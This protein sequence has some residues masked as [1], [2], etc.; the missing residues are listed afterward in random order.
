MN[1]K[2]IKTNKLL[3]LNKVERSILFIRGERVMI[4]ADLAELYGVTTK[5]L[6]EQVKRNIKRFPPD[7]MFQLTQEEKTEVVAN[8]DHLLML[9]FSPNLPSVFTEYGAI[10]AATILNSQYAVDMSILVV[11]AFVRLR[12]ILATHV[13]LAQKINELERQ[14][15]DKTTE[16]AKHINKIYR[17]L[18]ALMAPTPELKKGR[19][20]FD[21]GK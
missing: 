21:T 10:M 3:V 20:G 4:D 18:D 12:Y 2:L 1:N 19:I 16:H 14:F 13:E 8:C 6:N 7:F 15:K 17:I 9:K 5:R 11:R